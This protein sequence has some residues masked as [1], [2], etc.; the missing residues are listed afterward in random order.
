MSMDPFAEEHE[1]L[2]ADETN[3]GVT[4]DIWNILIPGEL[5]LPVISETTTI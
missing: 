3:V 4:P 2:F 1:L 5:L